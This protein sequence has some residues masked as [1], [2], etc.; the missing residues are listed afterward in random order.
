MKQLQKLG[1]ALAVLAA[2]STVCALP[3]LAQTDLQ[4]TFTTNPIA[5][6]PGTNGYLTLNLRALG[7]TISNIKIT[8]H[9]L[10]SPTIT[11]KGNWDVTVGSLAGGATYQVPYEFTVS[12]NASYGL[13]QIVFDIQ[14]SGGLTIHQTAMI[15]ITQPTAV[16]I[17][18]VSPAIVSIGQQ[19]TIHFNLTN[20][21]SASIYHVLFSWADADNLILPVGS[22]NR[23]LINELPAGNVTSVPVTLMASPTLSPGIY[24]LTITLKFYDDAG[25]NQT[26]I[27]TVGLQVSGATTFD[28]VASQSTSGATSLTIIN[29]GA[30]K[31]NSVIVTV[32]Q[33]IDYTVTGSSM[34]NV[35]NLDPGDYS[36]ASF[37]VSS[38]NLSGMFSG[39]GTRNYS[40][41]PPSGG[42]FSGRNF[43]QN[44]T[45]T[46][47]GGSGLTILITYTDSFGVRQTVQKQVTLSS[48]GMGSFS[49]ISRT[50]RS[51]TGPFGNAQSSSSSGGG[52]E[53][54]IVGII[55]IVLIVAVV[56]IGRK[57]KLAGV[58][59]LLKRRRE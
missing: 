33:Q 30:N 54:I 14:Y 5:V 28:V 48:S 19:S 49:S 59:R 13:Y 23:I 9:I 39:N 31:A 51:T 27:S 4:V 32:P 20:T 52:L 1:L 40:G 34:A 10:D 21:G 57:G 18:A 26:M 16:D 24:P 58:S 37:Q 55:G 15:Q 7:D 29:T 50:T 22:D 46:G 2:L 47:F 11:A 56:Y 35:G 42:N 38:M 12:R 6:A 53:Y 36:L 43:L 44:R 8:A 3:A 41:S 17:S 45:F 25:Q